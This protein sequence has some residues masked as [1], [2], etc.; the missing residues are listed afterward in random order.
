MPKVE[1]GN[2]DKCMEICLG[3]DELKDEYPS[4]ERRQ[5]ICYAACAEKYDAAEKTYQEYLVN[6]NK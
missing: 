4:I 6:K 3:D 2:I 5:S 1:G